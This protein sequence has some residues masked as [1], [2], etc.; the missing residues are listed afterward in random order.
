MGSPLQPRQSLLRRPY[1]AN[2][3]S[4]EEA[5]G[6]EISQE[7]PCCIR[8]GIAPPI[9]TWSWLNIICGHR[10]WRGL[11]RLRSSVDLAYLDGPVG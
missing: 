2:E 1:C 3:L 5:L 8:V 4:P 11:G 9:Q 10:H 6:F 7:I